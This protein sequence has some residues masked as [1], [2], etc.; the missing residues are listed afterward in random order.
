[1]NHAH[2]LC[3]LRVQVDLPLEPSEPG[4][5]TKEP[6]SS[7]NGVGTSTIV[8][9]ELGSI[10]WVMF[11]SRCWLGD[12]AHAD[13]IWPHIR[14][15]LREQMTLERNTTKLYVSREELKRGKAVVWKECGEL[16]EVGRPSGYC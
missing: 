15:D 5:R 6:G 4:E 7:L 14:K 2:E 1:M 10:D 12:E 13:Q 16:M 9:S 11:L 3:H 8:L